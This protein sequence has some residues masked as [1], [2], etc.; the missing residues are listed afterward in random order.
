MYEMHIHHDV[1]IVVTVYIC[2]VYIK[3]KWWGLEPRSGA[4]LWAGAVPKGVPISLAR[5]WFPPPPCQHQ[6]AACGDLS[7]D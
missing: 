5:P 6:K 7:Y 2:M 1:Y 3:S 4:E